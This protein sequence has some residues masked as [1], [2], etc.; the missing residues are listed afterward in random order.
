MKNLC[1]EVV[2]GVFAKRRGIVDSATAD[3]LLVNVDGERAPVRFKC[4]D[5]LSVFTIG[6]PREARMKVCSKELSRAVVERI[7]AL[8]DGAK[9]YAIYLGYGDG[10]QHFALLR[11]AFVA[12]MLQTAC[13]YDKEP[14]LRVYIAD[15][16]QNDESA[17]VLFAD[18][19]MP[20]DTAPA[21]ADL[22]AEWVVQCVSLSDV[23]LHDEMTAFNR[24]YLMR[25]ASG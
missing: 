13:E 24:R 10:W 18:S 15:Y 7:L 19:M 3:T 11:T 2:A 12:R 22:D 21:Y 9:F 17:R 4:D 5:L 8:T 16:S 14:L 6:L 23:G 25:A 20:R 1:V